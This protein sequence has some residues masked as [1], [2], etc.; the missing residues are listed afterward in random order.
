MY[1]VLHITLKMN[2]E[3]IDHLTACSDTTFRLEGIVDSTNKLLEPVNDLG[4]YLDRKVSTNEP[5]KTRKI[6]YNL[7]KSSYP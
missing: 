2:Q 6:K 3:T 1:N 7:T 5:G 4:M